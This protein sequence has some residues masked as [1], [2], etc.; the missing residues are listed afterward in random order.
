MKA[1]DLCLGVIYIWRPFWG[2]GGG[3]VRQK[4]DVIWR[5]RVGGGGR[6]VS[7]CSGRPTFFLLKKTGFTSWPDVMLTIC[8]WQEI[9]LLTLTSDGE[10]ILQ[11]YHC[12]VCGLN[13]TKERVVNLNMTWLYF[14]CFVLF[15]IS[16]IHVHGAIIK[17]GCLRFQVMQI[18]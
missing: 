4:W 6:G 15:L 16:F 11:W 7:E 14:F 1:L 9:F 12:I 18:K 8:Y 13:R 3:W 5:R 17:I 10:A 2:V